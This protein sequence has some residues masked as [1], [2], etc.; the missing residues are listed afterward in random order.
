MRLVYRLCALALVLLAASAQ[1]DWTPSGPVR[2]LHTFSAGSGPDI[3]ARI[4]AEELTKSWK[5]QVVVEP[6]PGAS[7][8]IAV[9]AVNK[10]APDGHAIVLMGSGELTINPSLN[11]NITFQA[12]DVRPIS[13]IYRT[14]FFV[15]A[16]TKTNDSIADIIKAAKAAP[17][18]VSYGSPFI[19]SPSHLGGALLEA[20]TGTRMLHVP[21][22]PPQ[23]YV[24]LAQGDITWALMT[25][26]TGRPYIANRQLRLLAVAAK[27][28]VSYAP[29]IPTVQEVLGG[30]QFETEAWVGILG[31]R[32]LP[33]PLVAS[34]HR[35]IEPILANSEVQKRLAGIGFEMFPSTT[36]DFVKLI[37]SDGTKYG[38]LIADL[39]LKQ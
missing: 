22:R 27:Q 39:N 17:G 20:Q 19:G 28:R 16:T 5:H 29:D 7:G 13:T 33:D 36:A 31:P 12:S 2:L 24:S 4:I 14:A 26:I 18:Q 38:K 10:A 3:A 37:T 25:E 11:K 34:I 15:T 9:D 21:A 30:P 8:G 6:R 32:N 35:A 1:A 23:A